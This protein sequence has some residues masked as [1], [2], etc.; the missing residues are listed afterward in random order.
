MLFGSLVVAFDEVPHRLRP[1]QA[2]GSVSN[3]DSEITQQ[4]MYPVDRKNA[5]EQ[6]TFAHRLGQGSG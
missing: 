6:L 3:I 5:D 4:V 2:P 1:S